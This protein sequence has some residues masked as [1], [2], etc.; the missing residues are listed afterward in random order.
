M[1]SLFGDGRTISHLTTQIVSVPFGLVVDA[2]I[3][4]VGENY[5]ARGTRETVA[6]GGQGVRGGH[7]KRKFILMTGVCRVKVVKT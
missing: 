5:A 1:V 4:D 7:L 2:L 6:G 3:F